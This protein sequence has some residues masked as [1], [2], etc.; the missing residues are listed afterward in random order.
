MGGTKQGVVVKEYA[1][2]GTKI[3]DI[4]ISH[5]HIIMIGKDCQWVE[6]FI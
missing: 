3:L 2:V 4:M 6:V 1:I 5:D